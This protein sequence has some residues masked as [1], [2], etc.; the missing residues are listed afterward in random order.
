MTEENVKIFYGV[1]DNWGKRFLLADSG[2]TFKTEDYCVAVMAKTKLEEG[3]VGLEVRQISE[4]WLGSEKLVV[5][6][7]CE[8]KW[9]DAK[10][11]RISSGEICMRCNVLREMKEER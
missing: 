7:E 9:I 10:N 11:V 6:Q 1:W 3:A 2:R 4:D 8:H 5:K